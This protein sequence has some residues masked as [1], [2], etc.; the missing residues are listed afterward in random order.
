MTLKTMSLDFMGKVL[1]RVGDDLR[2]TAGSERAPRGIEVVAV[3]CPQCGGLAQIP[4]GAK[5]GFCMFCCTQLLVDDGSRTVTYRSVDEARIREAELGAQLELRRLELEERSRPLRTKVV[6]ALLVVGV[7]LT[8]VGFMF[9][10]V[11]NLVIPGILL[12]EIAG[13][14]WLAKRLP[15]KRLE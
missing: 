11:Q 8:V 1:Q 5:S 7:V 4:A 13:I 6:L 9:K 15:D 14:V 10:D 3:E 12:I 2:S